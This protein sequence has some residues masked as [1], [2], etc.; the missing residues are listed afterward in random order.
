MSRNWAKL[1]GYRRFLAGMSMPVKH[2]DKRKLFKFM[3]FFTTGGWRADCSTSSE[4]FVTLSEP[5][6]ART[7]LPLPVFAATPAGVRDERGRAQ[8][9]A[10]RAEQFTLPPPPETAWEKR[11]RLESSR[12]AT[13]ERPERSLK[14][15]ETRADS[16]QDRASALRQDRRTDD[17]RRTDDTSNRD[18]SRSHSRKDS[19]RA[20]QDGVSESF[21][22][23]RPDNTNASDK[24]AD[25]TSA[26][27]THETEDSSD[28]S[29]QGNAQQATVDQNTPDSAKPAS[30]E[31]TGLSTEAQAGVIDAEGETPTLTSSGDSASATGTIAGAGQSDDATANLAGSLALAAGSTSST[32]ATQPNSSDP[33]GID[34]RRLSD[35]ATSQPGN[36]G[37]KQNS[38]DAQSDAQTTD[39]PAG[40]TSDQD[41]ASNAQADTK[42]VAA[43]AQTP[44]S[45][46]PASLSALPQN[47]A[48]Q[49]GVDSVTGMKVPGS[50]AVNGT[51]G[52]HGHIKDE[53]NGDGVRITAHASLGTVPI[54]IGI[55]ASQGVKRFDIRLDPYE[56]GRIDVKLEIDS[57]GE[58][59]ANLVVDRVETLNLLQRDARTLERA[60]EQVGLRSSEGS[61]NMSLRDPGTDQRGT[62]SD[63]DGR[64]NHGQGRT[65]GAGADIDDTTIQQVKF[66]R[67]GVGVDL[68]I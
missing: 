20:S 16:A 42:A 3:D 30:G 63:S 68:R 2:G 36:A 45:P 43:N 11:P 22:S 44:G 17:N 25:I 49:T 67:G 7:V 4:I 47:L 33:G 29:A 53:V 61:I 31:T 59:T 15:P 6:M 62:N 14:R 57:D 26:E 1:A 23:S 54:E 19:E 32:S 51:S 58:V 46:V 55:K 65:R 39:A 48:Q 52:G 37:T 56:L 13:P 35:L 24:A 27:A 60:F 38:Q 9:S 34:V 64:Q 10:S 40:K 28:T 21:T 41:V 66:R 18:A 5:A 50:E 12:P 8:A